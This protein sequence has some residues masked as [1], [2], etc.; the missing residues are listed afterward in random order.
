MQT[1]FKLII[2]MIFIYLQENNKHKGLMDWD[3]PVS[4]AGSKQ[5]RD[6]AATPGIEPPPDTTTREHGQG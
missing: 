6:K 4:L 1:F 2:K 5:K 3:F